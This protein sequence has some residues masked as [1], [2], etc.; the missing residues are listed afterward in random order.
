MTRYMHARPIHCARRCASVTSRSSPPPRPPG[1]VAARHRIGGTLWKATAGGCVGPLQH[2]LGPLLVAL[3]ASHRIHPLHRHRRGRVR[4]PLCRHRPGRGTGRL[5]VGNQGRGHGGVAW[6]DAGG[7]EYRARLRG[8]RRPLL[9]RQ[10]AG[11]VTRWRWRGDRIDRFPCA[12]GWLQ[13]LPHHGSALDSTPG[14]A[15]GA[16]YPGNRHI[17]HDGAPRTTGGAPVDPPAR[18]LRTR[19]VASHDRAGKRQ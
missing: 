14:G 12:S 3:G 19:V 5:G 16:A 9:R 6:C 11:R 1:R 15:A 2:R 4:R 13:P 10:R 17:S 8:D 18:E 7:C